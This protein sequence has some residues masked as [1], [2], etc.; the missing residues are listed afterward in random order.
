MRRNRYGRDYKPPSNVTRN[1]L[2]AIAATIAVVAFVW[3]TYDPQTLRL[4]SGVRAEAKKIPPAPEPQRIGAKQQ[5][6]VRDK[7]AP[8]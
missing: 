4:M 1:L 8:R 5:S 6:A 2:V 7:G 3:T